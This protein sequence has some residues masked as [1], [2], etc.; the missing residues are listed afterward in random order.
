MS[1]R[2][3]DTRILGVDNGD[4]FADIPVYIPQCEF[5]RRKIIDTLNDTTTGV[6]SN[7][8][9]IGRLL[10]ISVVALGLSLAALIIAAKTCYDLKVFLKAAQAIEAESGNG[11]TN[12][13]P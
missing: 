5:Q 12:S 8:T 13:R 7:T 4:V 11:G 6:D 1:K 2:D 9:S 10:V 3:A